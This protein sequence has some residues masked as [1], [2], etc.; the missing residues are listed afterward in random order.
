MEEAQKREGEWEDRSGEA[1]P[2]KETKV[3]AKRGD[4]ISRQLEK[5]IDPSIPSIYE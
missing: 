2:V 4:N 5:K 3:D 1:N